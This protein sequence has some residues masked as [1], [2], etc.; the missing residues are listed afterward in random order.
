MG[1]WTP[2]LA[3]KPGVWYRGK[4]SKQKEDQ[5]L[6]HHYTSEATGR[7]YAASVHK[8]AARE[9]RKLLKK[10]VYSSL[11]ESEEKRAASSYLRYASRH[12]CHCRVASRHP[13]VQ[14]RISSSHDRP[15]CL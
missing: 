3:S 4:G 11:E 14:T 5:L 9:G 10:T 6:L 13:E 2:F 7:I 1:I 8:S 12:Y 15:R